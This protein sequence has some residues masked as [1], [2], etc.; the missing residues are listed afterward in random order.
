MMDF[1]SFQDDEFPQA[2]PGNKRAICRKLRAEIGHL[3]DLYQNA[4][5]LQNKRFLTIIEK[6]K[7]AY[8]PPFFSNAITSKSK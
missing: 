2:D 4:K 7:E 5:Y 8:L 1:E 6:E 3:D